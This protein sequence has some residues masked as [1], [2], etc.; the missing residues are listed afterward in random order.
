MR[1]DTTEFL[2]SLPLIGSS[3]S[4]LKN[5]FKRSYSSSFPATFSSLSL[6]FLFPSRGNVG[7]QRSSLQC[8]RSPFGSNVDAPR[9][10]WVP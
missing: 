10:G 6:L 5:G 7:K 8:P 2:S 4:Y 1:K 3:V 9:A